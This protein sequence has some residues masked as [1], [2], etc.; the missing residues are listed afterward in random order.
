MDMDGNDIIPPAAAAHCKRAHPQQ[1]MQQEVVIDPAL[2]ADRYGRQLLA[3]T[4]ST[5]SV[6]VLVTTETM[7][8]TY[9]LPETVYGPRP[10]IPATDHTI[11]HT[12]KATT[13]AGM[14]AQI[15]N[16]RVA[17]DMLHAHEKEACDTHDTQ[18]AQLG[19]AGMLVNKLQVQLA[20]A[21][22]C[23]KK[24]KGV[25]ISQMALLALS[26]TAVC[27]KLAER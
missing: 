24:P 14:S 26:L 10:A 2:L 21:E 8:S 27:W 9:H 13:P 5:S 12:P 17:L 20:N 3:A 15:D 1:E 25:R 22:H 18:A 19:L 6:S 16:L 4:L 7:V 23:R 11:L